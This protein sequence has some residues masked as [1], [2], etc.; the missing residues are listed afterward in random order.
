M[1]ETQPPRRRALITGVTG[2]DGSYLAELLLEQGYEVFGMV[3]RASTENFARI[4]HLRRDI[5]LVQADLLDQLSLITILQRLRPHEL[6]NLAAQSFVPTSWEQPMLTAEFNAV[7]VTRLLEAIRLVDRDIRFYQAS[8]SEMFGKVRE[9]P[10]TEQT[11][12]HP[13][14]PYGVAK[15]YGHHITVNYRESYGLFACSGILFNHESPRRGKE[16]VTRKITDAVARIKLGVGTELRLGNL[17]ARRDWG[18]AKDYVRAMLLM[19]Q[20]AQPDD[21]VVATGASHSVREAAET[22]FAH[23]GLDWRQYVREDTTL[24]RPAEVDQLIGNAAK[25]RERLGW[26]PTVDFRALIERMV[27]ADLEAVRAE[28]VAARSSSSPSGSAPSSPS[29]SGRGSG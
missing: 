4:E 14:S 26:Q 28:L 23:V 11:P 13:R 15:V 24:L 3:R 22:A 7:G 21:Y 10:Q 17:E 16:F 1:S 12:F 29:P 8:S 9:V 2:Q 6:Y 19:L 27:D 25:A 5:E 20:Q 18:Y